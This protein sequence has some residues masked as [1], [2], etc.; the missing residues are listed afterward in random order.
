MQN[1]QR[2]KHKAFL[3]VGWAFPFSLA[4][5]ATVA[6]VAFER[7]I[8]E[9]ICIILGTNPGERVMRPDFG[10]GHEDFIFAPVTASTLQRIRP[11]VMDALIDWE[12]RIDVVEVSVE[13]A[14]RLRNRLD[15][16][17]V[18]RVRATNTLNNL[19]YPFYLDE[20]ALA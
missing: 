12:P 13:P 2:S 17:V 20:G 5:D 11:R 6:L 14:S 10:A 19:V 4:D 16:T 3:G 1:S 15:I 9:A 7:D 8:Q 18:Y